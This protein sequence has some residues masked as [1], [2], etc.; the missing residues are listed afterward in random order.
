LAG[1][2][3][4]LWNCRGPLSRKLTLELDESA[5][6]TDPKQKPD[7]LIFESIVNLIHYKSVR[8]IRKGSDGSHRSS[9]YILGRRRLNNCCQPA[10]D[11]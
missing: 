10:F 3:L 7:L 9:R 11:R 4:L 1:D 2:C 8:E 6:I 5:A